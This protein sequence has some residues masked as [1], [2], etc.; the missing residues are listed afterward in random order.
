MKAL[1]Q[2]VFTDTTSSIPSWELQFRLGVG[3]G[4]SKAEDASRLTP[5]KDDN[6]TLAGPSPRTNARF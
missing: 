4:Q 6:E 3:T 1:Q 2:H 5:T